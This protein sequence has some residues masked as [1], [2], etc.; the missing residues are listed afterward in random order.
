MLCYVCLCDVWRRFG[1]YLCGVEDCGSCSCCFDVLFHPKVESLWPF[2]SEDIQS[3]NNIYL[4]YIYI[5]LGCG[6]LGG[7]V[8][9]VL[10]YEVAGS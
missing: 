7:L 8:N 10:I 5:L 2:T 6:G 3:N 1:L 4:V 9:T